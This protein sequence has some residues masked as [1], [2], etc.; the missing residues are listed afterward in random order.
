MRGEKMSILETQQSSYPIELNVYRQSERDIRKLKLS[1]PSTVLGVLSLEVIRRLA[2]REAELPGIEDIPDEG[3]IEVLCL[4]LIAEHDE[5]AAADIINSALTQGMTLETVYLKYLAE[6]ARMLGAWWEEDRVNFVE[7]TYGTGRM[8]AIM[9]SLR[10]M[11]PRVTNGKDRSAVFA[12]APGETHVLGVRMA[13]DLFR[14]DG[15]HVKLLVGLDHDELVA[16]IER[17]PAGVVGL[18][19]GGHH[20]IAALTR[21][22]LALHVACPQKSIV[23][24][25]KITDETSELISLMGVD[26]VARDMDEAR[27]LMGNLWEQ[28][29]G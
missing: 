13:A 4:A 5:T 25:G 26:G 17:S 11:F 15:W 7:V 14:K 2:E 24:C 27:L 28:S 3:D 8:V 22:V 12:S 16:E 23:I 29:Q 18:S 21:L 10:H 9:R 19:A 1:V 6:A 20:S